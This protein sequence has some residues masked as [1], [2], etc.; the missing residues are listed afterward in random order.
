MWRL[1]DELLRDFEKALELSYRNVVELAKSIDYRWRDL[2][3]PEACSVCGVDGSRGI[4]KLS[5]VVFYIISTTSVGNEVREMHE[6]TTLK[7]H[8]H[9]DER[10]RLHMHT[11]EFRL[12]S[13]AEE[14]IVL[15]DGTLRGAMIRPPAYIDKDFHTAL[16]NLYDIEGVVEDFV[17]VLDRWFDEITKDVMSGVARKNYLLTRTEYF[18]KIEAGCR[19]GKESDVDN[20]MILMEYVEYLHS[21]DRLLEKNVVFVAK[22]FYTNEFTANMSITDSA[23]LDYLA[24]EQ[25]GEEKAG[26]IPF[27][28][29]LRKTLP[30]YAKKFENLKTDIYGAFV[31]FI[32]GGSIYLLESPHPIDEELIAKLC[33]LEA[34]GY[35][36]PL[37][38]AHRHAEIKRREMRNIMNAMLSA[39]NPKYSFL[40]KKG[41]EALE[42]F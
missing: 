16:S 38:H 1:S 13:L 41:R 36:I 25:F 24:I 22:S 7:P 42:R 19:K 33:S 34:D 40:L 39:I 8:I 37:I 32:D 26:Y 11:S 30:W 21:L 12:G 15:M 9:V 2:P 14:E 6:L 28:P 31:R 10:I 23:V 35:L 4:E 29:E 17:M 5:G 18:N 27:K 20:L 3:A